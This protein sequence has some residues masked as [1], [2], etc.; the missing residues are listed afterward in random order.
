M[1]GEVLARIETHDWII[2]ALSREPRGTLL[3]VPAGTGALAQRIKSLGFSVFCCDINLSFFSAPEIE[4]K[5][6]DLNQSL[7]YPTGMFDF[8]T[9]IEGLEHLENPFNAIREFHRILNPGGKL[10]ISLPNYLNIERRLRF[11]V[12]G[13][14][15]KVPSPATLGKERF[16]NLWMLHLIPLTYP[17]LKLILEHEGFKVLFIDKDKE[18]K[19][20]KWLLPLVWGIRF[21]CYFWSKRQRENYHL[22]DT[23]SPL[24]IMG[25]N[26]LI[27]TAMKES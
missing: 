16:E 8:V 20:M 4:I 21:Y 13:L 1:A 12:T 11:L 24:L 27:V 7:P 18:K 23:L 10:I 17:I 19:R 5:R 14:F 22:K 26:T 25:G 2:D 15:S 3:D 9:C 6:G